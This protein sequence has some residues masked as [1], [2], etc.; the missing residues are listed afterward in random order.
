MA[1][2]L[3]LDFSIVIYKEDGWW[4]AHCLET[5]LPAEGKTP[6]AALKNLIEL[7]NFQ[8]EAALEEGNLA[9][10]FTAAP[11][12]LWTMYASSGDMALEKFPRKPNKSVNRLSV[13]E[14]V[15]A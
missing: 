12:H 6:N 8:L 15:S 14:L 13:R 4:I 10:I 2:K 1:S 3:R 9:S 11:P 7:T 5:D